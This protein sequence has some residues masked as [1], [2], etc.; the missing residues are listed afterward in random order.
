M[1]GQKGT[2]VVKL[3]DAVKGYPA[4]TGDPTRA[5]AVLRENMGG[6]RLTEFDLERVKI[7]AGGGKFWEVPG[8]DGPTPTETIEGV[9]VLTKNVRAY[10]PLALEEGSGSDP[11]QC[12]SPDGIQGYG[13]PGVACESCTYAQF[14]SARDGRGQACKQMR[15]LF[16]LTDAS[17]LPVVLTLPPTS[18][19]TARKYFMRLA[20]QGG[21]R[22]YWQTTTKISL[23]QTKNAGGQGYSRATF[24]AGSPL[25]D[26]DSA[27]VQRYKDALEPIL[28]A[29]MPTAEEAASA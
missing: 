6:E 5:L 23:E 15:Q 22:Y 17:V 21:G 18:L 16:L 24:T 28:A 9:V 11:P 19:A 26:D 10:W 1:A 12:T 2:D 3:S 29:R 20:S 14:G 13:D 7:P 8:M 4:L 27:A 25:T